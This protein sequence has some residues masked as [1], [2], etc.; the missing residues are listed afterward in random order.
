[1]SIDEWQLLALERTVIS[2]VLYL[3]LV[4][5]AQLQYVQH[6]LNFH[7]PEECTFSNFAAVFFFRLIKIVPMKQRSR[8]S[9]VGITNRYGLDDRGSEFESR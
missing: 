3:F 1:M 7:S 5:N 8:D 6:H 4:F 2:A 9:A